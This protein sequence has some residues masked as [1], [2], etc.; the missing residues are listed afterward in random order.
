MVD[1]RHYVLVRV[2]LPDRP[3]ALG[4]VASRIGALHGDIMGIDVL[5]RSAEVAMDEFAVAIASAEL[6]PML[7]REIEEVDGVAVTDVR[8]VERA[9][10][11]GLLESAA[12]LSESDDVEELWAHL[13]TE[14]RHE[15][16]ADGVVL[17]DDDGVLASAGPA[18]ATA[19]VEVDQ[20]ADP[21]AQARAHL[22]QRRVTL[23]AS[24]AGHPFRAQERS[25]VEL[26]AR[27]ADRV[28]TLLEP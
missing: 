5:E 21:G 14:V 27:I 10:G 2:S 6:V 1:H 24:R 13:V 25:R 15:L 22:P 7:V 12:R 17:F 11:V 26:L 4:Q 28:G 9:A 16:R 3:G 19:S 20:P 23:V 18:E 8:A